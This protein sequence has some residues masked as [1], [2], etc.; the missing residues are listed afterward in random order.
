MVGNAGRMLHVLHTLAPALH[1]AVLARQ[2]ERD[3]FEDRS[4][5]KTPGNL[6]DALPHYTGTSGGWRGKPAV[7]ARLGLPLLALGSVFFGWL[8]WENRAIARNP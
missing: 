8:W 5:S 3:H 6:F 4:A 7:G 2:V 1:D